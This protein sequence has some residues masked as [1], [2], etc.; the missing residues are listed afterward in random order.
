VNGITGYRPYPAYRDS[1]VE[2]LGEVPGH[3][4]VK[5][6]GGAVTDCQNG[7]WGEEPADEQGVICVRVADFDR[8]TLR[9]DV[10]DP[11]YRSIDERTLN[12]RRLQRGDLLLEKSGG[13]DKQLV[14]AVMLFDHD[15]EAVC[16]NF[17]A[18]MPVVP[19]HSPDYLTYLHFTLYAGRLNYRSIKQNT[20]IQ[21]LDSK[22]YLNEHVAFPPLPEQRAIAAFL[23]H[24][25]A[26]IDALIAQ[27]E[28]LIALLQ[29]KRAALITTA[30]TRGLDPDVAM[31]DSGVEWLGE[32]PAH[33][34]VKKFKYLGV[35][36]GGGTP[37]KADASLWN[38]VVPWVSPKDMK[39]RIIEDSEDHISVDAIEFSATVLLPEGSMLVVVRSGI[40][41]HSIPVAINRVP[42]TINQDMKALIP[43]AFVESGYLA[44]LVEGN[45]NAL[46]ELWRKQGATV[47]SIEYESLRHTKVSLPSL[48]EQRAIAAFLDHKTA[49]IDALIA[50][51]QE[52]I[53]RLQ[54]Y[55]TA[56]I[57]AAVTGKIDVRDNESV[58][59]GVE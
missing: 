29:E 57:S 40:L 47:E 14:G 9:I 51:V 21:N 41:R 8:A 38:G 20:G 25:T 26:E 31:K 22:S 28:Q 34:E 19:D 23:D 32:V 11:T 44:Y 12:S 36:T 53:E 4:E 48:V 33:W 6:I 58:R 39:K 50:K 46:L 5:R 27:K 43:F 37:S 52:G 24:K 3:W 59:E 15:V 54:E 56:L 45:Q 55:R 18:R 16:S 35:F 7:V 30:V 10:S 17:V 2:W 13:G 1:G 49:E 42:V